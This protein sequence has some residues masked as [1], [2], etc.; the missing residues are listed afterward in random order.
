MSD[1]FSEV[2]SID[3]PII[4]ADAHVY[5]PPDV[6]QARVPKALRARAPQVAR[7][8]EGDVWSFDQGARLRPVGLMAAAG[9][10][11]LDFRPS[12][13]TYESIRRGHYEVGA[14]LADMDAD[15]IHAQ[16]LY[17]SV[18]EEGARMFGDDRALQLACV[19]A[20]NEWLLEFC[21]DGQ[22]RLFGHAVIPATGLAD[23]VAE[24]EWALRAGY[25]GALI[26]TFP[27][28]GVEPSPDDDPF[29][30][31]AEE[32]GLPVALHI[33]SFHADGPVQRRRF[34]PA[35]VLPRAAVSK[36]G[37]NT[38]PLVARM[39][40]SGLF[41]RV[42]RLRAVLVEANI[43][44]I[45]A[46]L[47]Q[48]DDMFLRYRWF[49]GTAA[50]LP[51]LPSRAFHRNVWATFMIDTVGIELRHR[52]NIDH[53]MWSTDYPHTGT[54]W[55]NSR[56]TIARLFRGVPRDDVK[57]MLHGNCKAL[58]ALGEVPDRWPA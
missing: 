50:S 45:P 32:A 17:P 42:P 27:S 52:L 11:Y 10:S 31:R 18:C 58:Y 28:G 15:G 5:E 19:R 37:A 41:E 14:R 34:E 49:T 46:M 30:A 51:T 22:G 29:W 4:D 20:Y 12:G 16:L 1:P 40:F 54:D 53:L 7:T 57:R 39:I 25:R 21:A 33:G 2:A 13:L 38:V 56:V 48:T 23:A 44:W 9:A 35:A 6:W 43:G 3:Y 47:E 36:S 55:P 8:D 24:I 26:S